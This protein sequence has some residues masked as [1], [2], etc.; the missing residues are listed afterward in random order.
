VQAT[1]IAKVAST[2]NALVRF[3]GTTGEVQN[4]LV[5]VDDAGRVGFGS[6]GASSNSLM[7]AMFE[8]V[9][10]SG[11]TQ[12]GILFKPTYPNDVTSDL[13]NFY[14]ACN[15][16]AGAN[17]VNAYGIFVEAGNYAGSSVTNKYGIFQKGVN[18][19]NYFAGN[20]LIGTTTDDGVNKL[21]VSGSTVFSVD[22][23]SLQTKNIVSF[24]AGV[25]WGIQFKQHHT[26]SA[27][28]YHLVQKWGNTSELH[29]LTFRSGQVGIGTFEPH[30][31]S[32][33]DIQ[34]TTQGV[35][36]PNMTTAQKNAITPNAAGNVVFDTTLGKLCV[37][38]GAG[39]QTITSA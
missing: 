6:Q 37:N 15:L 27:I 10:T 36:F 21:Q 1:A 31:S 19:C 38:T 5:V 26:G 23:T 39:G 34:S 29:L 13:I 35:R 20:V 9:S 32:K 17:L 28:Q 16:T 3:N 25:N 18:D 24:D 11:A 8:G 14:A 4:S 2:D 30:Q 33:V 12:F 7:R 22:T